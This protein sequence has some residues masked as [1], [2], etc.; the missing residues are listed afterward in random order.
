MVPDMASWRHEDLPA[1]A[2]A[3]AT[4][5]GH[6]AVRTQITLVPDKLIWELRTPEFNQSKPLHR[7]LA[8]AALADDGIARRIDRLVARL[9]DR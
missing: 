5:P 3:L 8:S 2:A 4:R 9:L 1:L 7:E 6:E